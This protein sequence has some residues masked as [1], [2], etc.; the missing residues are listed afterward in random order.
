MKA[1]TQQELA[2]PKTFSLK[3]IVLKATALA[4]ALVIASFLI[5]GIIAGWFGYRYLVQVADE[6]DRTPKQLFQLAKKLSIVESRKTNPVFLILGSD[7]IAG[8][9]DVPPLTDTILLVSL[10]LQSGTAHLLPLPRDIWSDAYKTKI[11]ALYAYGFERY[12]DEPERFPKEVLEEMSNIS[13]DFTV[14]IDMDSLSELVTILGGVTVNVPNSFVDTLFPIPGVDVTIEQDP[15]KLY[16]TVAFAK[17]EE[18]M[19]GERFLEFIRSRHSDSAEG[20]DLARSE[21]QKLAI[22]AVLR[23]ISDRLISQPST[24]GKLFSFYETRFSTA[25]PLE[26]IVA[27]GKALGE[28]AVTGLTIE[29]AVLSIQ[30]ATESGVLAHPNIKMTNGTWLYQITNQELFQAEVNKALDIQ[31]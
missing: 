21:R 1:V 23:A 7:A 25:V 11:N 3:S 19:S 27:I 14:V 28:H 9:G 24:L 5:F 17:G 4:I 13:I 6:T 16:K 30:S 22:A 26:D 20:T 10:D 8:R 29:S 12:P 2:P 31:Q 15:N 18:S